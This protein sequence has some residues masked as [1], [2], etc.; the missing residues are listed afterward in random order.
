MS[1]IHFTVQPR[2]I[3]Y[4]F[5]SYI[6]VIVGLFFYSFTQVDLNLTLSR[7]TIIQQIQAFF[8]H[9][10][11]FNRPL[12]TTLYIVIILLLF[13]YYLFF[14][15]YSKMLI[16]KHVW[17]LLFVMT[18][19][20]IFSY[21]TFSYD[22]FNYIFDARIVTYYHQN[23][24]LY[25]ALDFPQDHMLTFMRWTHRTYPYGPVWLFIT[26]PMS[27]LGMQVFLP[28]FFLF[29]MI[30]GTAYLL[31][32]YFIAKIV[33]KFS[34][35]DE[36]FAVIFFCFNPLVIIESLVSAHIDIVMICLA[37]I[38][39]YALLN[40]KFLQSF[41]L[42]SLSIGIKYVTGLLL[43]LYLF[44]F[45]KERKKEH[46]NLQLFFLMAVVGLTLAIV[47]ETIGIQYQ[48]WRLQPQFQPWYLLAVIPFAAFL[49]NK[50]YILI[51]TVVMSFVA[52]LEYIPYL[53]TGN[54]NPPI[55]TILDI[56]TTTGIVFSIFI[57]GIIKLLV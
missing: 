42:L 19:L 43:P 17:I 20:L 1:R 47:A 45:F 21:N 9:I 12:S 13:A 32:G 39:L 31:T 16:K 11:Y 14:L 6:F 10:G 54:W 40:K 51:P 50:L 34:L 3:T 24:Y 36:S 55:P 33:R 56:L 35:K 28:T 27:Y 53:F 38:S 23:P 29:K 7:V 48:P 18:T 52:L 37:V 2:F 41:I 30:M 44:V 22:I 25:K 49:S 26:I 4:I 15:Q 5:F 46:W 8:Q 57:V